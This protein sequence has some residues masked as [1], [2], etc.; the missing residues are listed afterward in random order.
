ML[1]SLIAVL[2]A[3]ALA[4]C[5]SQAPAQSVPLQ[6]GPWTNGHAPMYS[7]SGNSQ[8]VIQDSGPAGGGANGLGMSEGLYVA[9]GTGTPPYVGQGTG[10]LGTNWCDY[11]AP[12]TNA[13]GYHYLC[14]SANVNNAGLIAY[15]AGGTASQQPLKMNLNGTTYEFPFVLSGVVGP[16]TS[17]VGH[18]ALWNNTTGT[19]LSDA[20]TL[21]T[22]TMP[23]LTGD[24]TTP[25]A[26]LVTTCSY[27]QLGTG[28][29]T[30]SLKALPAQDVVANNF[31]GC[32]VTGATDST[33]C[34]QNAINYAEVRATNNEQRVLL[35][36]GLYKVSATLTV[37]T[38]GVQ[39]AGQNRNCVQLR[40]F[41]DYG[42]SIQFS[43]ASGTLSNVGLRDITID[44]L[45]AATGAAGFMSCG[46]SPYH[47]VVDGV[48]G[49]WMENVTLAY[50]CGGLALQGVINSFITNLDIQI[51]EIS[52]HSGLDGTGTGLYVG[53]TVN[54]NIA[55]KYSSNLWFNSPEIGGGSIGAFKLADGIRLDGVDGIWVTSGHVQ[56]AV[57]AD[58]HWSHSGA[59]P[60]ANI[61]FT[62]TM[63]DITTGNGLLLNGTQQVLRS[64][65]EGVLSAA[66][67]GGANKDG[68]KITG[69]G[70][71]NNVEFNVSVDGFGGNGIF[72]DATNVANLTIRPKVIRD[73][74]FSAGGASSINMATGSNIAIDGG[75]IDGSTQADH[76][77][78]FGNAVS[79]ASVSGSIITAHTTDGVN[80]AASATYITLTGIN[81]QG[82]TAAVT[83]AAAVSTVSA[84]GN[85]GLPYFTFVPV[86]TCGTGAITTYTASGR[87]QLQG[88]TAAV[89]IDVLDTTNGTCAS[90]MVVSLPFAGKVT[91]FLSGATNVATVKSLKALIPA[92]V[93]A[94]QL[95]W[96]DNTYPGANTEHLYASGTY[97]VQ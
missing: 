40:R 35:Q 59:Y 83:N 55:V 75:T 26:S 34:I 76:G 65:Y 46:T 52:G 85:F 54:A 62:N 90:V 69:T 53:F 8:P 89:S 63:A 43:K 70:G 91:S 88:N 57:T 38:D 48:N 3:A 16:A 2:F 79:R 56:G 61:F 84:T 80:I 24:C 17:T 42:P 96:Y 93:S 22:P 1:R 47:V 25:G 82:N 11:D 45:A 68:I 67:L 29:A 36:C 97:E 50:G 49:F 13:T 73:N 6:G 30:Q 86:V 72:N 37:N 78:I 41:T 74:D 7:N 15:G 92:G 12:I 95:T 10:P 21:P 71:L 94:V 64:K 27:T 32:D 23:A 4:A 77:I 60:M 14:L 58:Y 39:I 33:T 81:F 19:L 9:R 5:S 66:E 51:F 20:A 87:Y 28:G 44:D 31:T 18:L